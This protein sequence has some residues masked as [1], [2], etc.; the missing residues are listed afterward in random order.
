MQRLLLRA[1]IIGLSV[2]AGVLIVPGQTQTGSS[3]HALGNLDDAL[4]HWPLPTGE[5]RYGAIDGKHLHGYVVEQSA[6]SRRYRDQGHAKFW[7]H[8]RNF[9]RRRVR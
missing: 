3:A 6:I 2:L 5:E 9:G 4:L 1:R 8:H 7:A